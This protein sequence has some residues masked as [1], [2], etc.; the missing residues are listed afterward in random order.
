MGE[1]CIRVVFI[2]LI[3]DVYVITTPKSRTI[4]TLPIYQVIISLWHKLLPHVK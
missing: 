1:V 2:A 4:V 3:A